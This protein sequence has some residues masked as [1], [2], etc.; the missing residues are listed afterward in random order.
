MHAWSPAITGMSVTIMTAVAT[1][2]H[3]FFGDGKRVL[4]FRGI[5]EWLLYHVKG[6]SEIERKRDEFY[7]SLWCIYIEINT[8]YILSHKRCGTKY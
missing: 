6:V 3:I 1:A 8:E 4:G 5:F 2:D 7:D